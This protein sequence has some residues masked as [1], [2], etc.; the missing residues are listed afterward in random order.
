[1]ADAFFLPLVAISLLVFIRLVPSVLFGLVSFILKRRYLKKPSIRSV[2]KNG[3][4][5]NKTEK[6]IYD[7]VIVGGGPAGGCFAYY[8]AKA[9]L[10]VVILERAQFPRDKY[11]G[12]A[13]CVPAIRILRDMDILKDFEANNEVYFSDSGGFISPSGQGYLGKSVLEV[14][15]PLAG[16]IKRINLDNRI[17]KK[18]VEIGAHLEELLE[19]QEAT[20]SPENKCWTVT[21]ADGRKFMGRTLICA[22]GSPSKLARN[23]GYVTEPPKG[24]STRAY[25]EGDTHNALMDGLVVYPPFSLPGYCAVFKHPNNELNFCYYLIPCGKEDQLGDVTEKDLP[26]LHKFALNEDPFI[27]RLIGD[28]AKIEPMRV[29]PLRV[30]LQGVKQSYDDHLLII[31][32]AAGFVDPLTGEGIHNAMMSGRDGAYTLIDMHREGDFSAASAKQYEDRWMNSFGYDFEMSKAASTLIWKFPIV[33][34]ACAEEM[35]VR[36]LCYSTSKDS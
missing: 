34:D 29:A 19:V 20:F 2:K 13:I 6:D 7:A 17:V 4:F 27:H 32:D 9:N 12:N 11:C 25:I 18:A 36:S 15:E 26:L 8:A 35:Q 30:G 22:D 33:L 3:P 28:K 10:N 21:S 23:L 24:I 1:M 16:A 31:G 14:G 5:K